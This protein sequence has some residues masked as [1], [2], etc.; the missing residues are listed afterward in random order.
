MHATWHTTIFYYRFFHTGSNVAQCIRAPCTMHAMWCHAALLRCHMRTST[1]CRYVTLVDVGPVTQEFKRW[2][3]DTLSSISS[4]ATFAWRRHWQ[5]LA[6]ISTEFCVVSTEHYSFC[7]TYS[8]CHTG[9]T[10]DFPMLFQ[11][12]LKHGFHRRN[13]S[14]VFNVS[15]SLLQC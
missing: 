10:L 1:H 14:S 8:Q 4:L 7:F 2:K 13:R 11:F 3:A 15:D 5:T 9:Y 6:A 12:G